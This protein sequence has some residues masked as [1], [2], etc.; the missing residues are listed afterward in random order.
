MYREHLEE[1]GFLYEHRQTLLKERQVAWRDVGPFEERLEAHV[2]ALVVGGD[3][4]LTVSREGAKGGEPSELFPAVSL[5]CRQG[6]ADLLSELLS[7]LDFNEVLKTKAVEQA[8]QIELPA[9]W[10][11]FCQK[12][13]LRGGEEGRTM[14]LAK[15]L[16][17]KRLSAGN[18]A[19][20]ILSRAPAGARPTLAWAFGRVGAAGAVEELTHCLEQDDPDL[21]AAALLALLRLGVREPLTHCLGAIPQ[22]RWP[23]LALGLGGDRGT[24]KAL[25]DC[26]RGGTANADCILGLGLLGDLRVVRL[27][28]KVLEYPELAATAA[29]ALDLITGA[30]IYEDVF[31]PEPIVEVELFEKELQ[32]W[33][34]QG[35]VPTHPD[36]RFLGETVRRITQKPEQ[37]HAWLSEHAAVFNPKWRY[38]NGKPYSPSVLLEG[39]FDETTP[40]QVRQLTAEEL[41]VR[42]DCKIAF[43]ADMP[44]SQ[45]LQALGKMAGWVREHEGRFEPGVWYFNASTI[46]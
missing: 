31:V 37:W 3:L 13:L 35:K 21:K 22:E 44:V 43:E 8:L 42:Y 14:L 4:A 10:E 1:A 39:L 41:A 18:E 5:F 20:E 11:G 26:V 12:A 33:K 24:S 23:Y 25:A 29:T 17:Y 28:L 19:G 40:Y 16:G 9:E 15:V 32:D 45:Q 27:L 7:G 2:D 6:R 46:S 30:R 38:R 36:G 34:E